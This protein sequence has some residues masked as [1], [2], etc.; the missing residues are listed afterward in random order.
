MFRDLLALL[1]SEVRAER[2]FDDACAIQSLDRHFTFGCFQESA[3]LS[4]SRLREAGLTEVEVMQAP[5]DGE[6]V[7]GDWRMP[8]AWEVEAATFD[9][10]L[11]NGAWQRLADRARIPQCL[12]MW[13]GPTPGEGVEAELV[14]IRNPLDRASYHPAVVRGK[15]VFTG[16]H[17]HQVKKLLADLGVAGVI[18]DYMHPPARLPDATAWV[19]SFSDDADGWGFLKGDTP[20]WCFLISPQQGERLRACMGAHGHAALRGR[21]V[22]RSRLEAGT[23]PAVTGVIPG[24]TREEV[25][26]IGHQFEIGAIDNAAGVA[27]MMEAV[28]A[29]QRLISEG[30]LPA[31]KRS[32]RVLFVSECYSNLHFWEKTRRHLRTV[33]GLCLDSPVGDPSLALR[34]LEVHANPHSQMSYTDAL[35][36][37]LTEEAMAVPRPEGRDGGPPQAGLA[38][39]PL[40]AWREAAFA[41]TDNLIADTS[42]GIPC[43]WLGGHSRTWHTSADTPD[44]LPVA[45]MGLVAQLTAAYAYLIAVAGLREALD[46]ADLAAVRGKKAI[47]DAGVGAHSSATQSADDLDD[48]MLQV[49]YLADRHADA[50]GSVFRLLPAA[51]RAAARP[52]VRAL[53]REVR[54]A[55]QEEAAALARRAGR[56][57]REPTVEPPDAALAAVR[58]RRLVLGPITFDRLTAEQRGGRQSPRW[59]PAAFAL[60]SWCDGKRSLAKAAQLAARELRRAR[61]A[62]PAELAKQID[63]G[64]PS[65]LDYCEFLRQHGYLAW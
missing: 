8:L 61:T 28:R 3:R 60:L 14:L 22:V 17:P 10:L 59:S 7:F 42:I 6:S 41:M 57:D 36:A 2:A 25:V 48:A 15:M 56:P 31:P 50:V 21:A 54:R 19:N 38:T 47:A 18:S 62:G 29:L 4:A 65:L 33:A 44:K 63:S 16:A 58:P 53:Q 51:E 46:F 37:H 35:A 13:S 32:I 1:A 11:P 55:G 49:G 26:L 45:A 5:A 39:D 52:A 64:A 40:Y 27:I 34:P 23:L 12:A 30:K 20:A 24:T 9:L 43:P